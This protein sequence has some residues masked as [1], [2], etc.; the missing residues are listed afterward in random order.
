MVR[1]SLFRREHQIIEPG[2]G[3]AIGT[4]HQFHQQHAFEK[5]IGL[6]HTHASG[7]KAAQGIHFHALPGIFLRLAP[8]AGA[9]SPWRGR[10]DCFFTLRPSV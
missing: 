5:I 6:R 2:G 8:I 10:G 9:S 4:G 7:G 3:I 1:T